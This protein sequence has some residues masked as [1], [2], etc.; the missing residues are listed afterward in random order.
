V[1]GYT[2]G[3]A[4]KDSALITKERNR[5]GRDLF[6]RALAMEASMDRSAPLGHGMQLLYL[7][8][9][10]CGRGGMALLADL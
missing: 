2:N 1:D 6:E 10:Q 7:N 3:E 8:M 9:L 4:G 5:G